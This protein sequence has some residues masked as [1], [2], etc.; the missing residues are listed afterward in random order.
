MPVFTKGAAAA[1]FILSE[2]SGSRSRDT[3]VIAAGAG[4]VAPGSVLGKVTASGK[5]LV[6]AIGAVDG[7]QTPAAISIY[8]CDATTADQKVA[9]ISR[10]AEVNRNCLTYH[11]DRNLDAEKTS[12]NVSLAA[13]GIIVR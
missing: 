5:Y 3:V 1:E 12:A 10:D 13:Q 8:G 9:V 7:S 6:S 2:A 4:I 11:A